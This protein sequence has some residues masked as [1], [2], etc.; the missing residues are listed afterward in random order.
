MAVAE[1]SAAFGSA[2]AALELLKAGKDTLDRAAITSAIAEI[3]SKLMDAQGM[4]LKLFE[5]NLTLL[6]SNR[7]LETKLKKQVDWETERGAYELKNVTPGIHAWVAKGTSSGF[8]S[9]LKLCP[10]CFENQVRSPLQHIHVR[11]ATGSTGG[12]ALFCPACNAKLP[13][14]GGYSA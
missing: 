4:A 1:I 3:Q 8:H 12:E 2:K 5:D 10:T 11:T 7:E 13:F 6:Q 14:N 9:A